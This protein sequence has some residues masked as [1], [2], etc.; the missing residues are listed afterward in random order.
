MTEKHIVIVGLGN[1]GKKYEV[2]RHNL[3]FLVVKALARKQGWGFKENKDIGAFISKNTF[4]DVAVHLVLPTTYMNNSGTAV[5]RYLDYFKLTAENL[6]VATDDIA[7]PFGQIRVRPE[8]SA[9]GHNGLKSVELHLGTSQYARLRMGIG[10]HRKSQEASEQP[11]SLADYVLGDFTREEVAGLEEF[12]DQGAQILMRF[13]KEPIANIM[14]GVNAS[15]D[16]KLKELKP[17][18]P[19]CGAGE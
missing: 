15:M 16:K 11:I 9:G 13:L 1:P 14:N 2:T 18:P 12:I 6:V 19:K 8:G 7:L 3:G 5:R 17:K 4:D 10:N